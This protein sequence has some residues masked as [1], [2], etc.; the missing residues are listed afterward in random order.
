MWVDGGTGIEASL[1]QSIRR[2]RGN[3]LFAETTEPQEPREPQEPVTSPEEPADDNR[4]SC[5]TVVR[6]AAPLFADH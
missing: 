5:L 6:T 1:N 4:P 3:W 2:K